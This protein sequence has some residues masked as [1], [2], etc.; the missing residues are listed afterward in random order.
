MEKP[1]DSIAPLDEEAGAADAEND[2]TEEQIAAFFVEADE[3]RA[4]AA[5]RVLCA[6]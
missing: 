3:V 4:P 5:P 1:D 2:K 6:F